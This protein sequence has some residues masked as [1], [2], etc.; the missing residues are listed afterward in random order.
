[1]CSR[2][3]LSDPLP[4]LFGGR[5]VT[6]FLFVLFPVVL[7]ASYLEISYLRLALPARRA[8][9]DG[10]ATPILV[11]PS[12]R[13]GNSSLSSLRLLGLLELQ[14]G[15]L[16]VSLFSLFEPW[17]PRLKYRIAMDKVGM[18]AS[19]DAVIITGF[20][21]V[22]RLV[23]EPQRP[24]WSPFTTVGAR[25]LSNEAVSEVVGRLRGDLLDT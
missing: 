21:T 23:L 22:N 5:A 10:R 3:L 15:D 1:M 17:S 4:S 19:G 2:S 16:E 12:D 8:A 9:M 18:T 20:P 24:S 14:G 6:A 13:D 11:A 25:R 7:V